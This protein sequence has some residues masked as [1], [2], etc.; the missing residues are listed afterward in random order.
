MAEAV[1]CISKDKDLQGTDGSGSLGGIDVRRR[2]PI[3]LISKQSNRNRVPSRT[4][5]NM[6][7]NSSKSLSTNEEGFDYNKEDIYDCK[8]GEVFGNQRRF[9]LQMFWDF[10]INLLGEKDDTPIH[11]C[12]KCGLPIKIYGRMIP[13]KHVFCFECASLHEKKGDKICPGCNDPVQRIEQ[14]L[15]GS[16]FMCSIVQGCKRTY[17]SQRDLQAHINHRHMRTGKPALR[18]QSEPLHPAMAPPG[19]IPERF[20]MPPDKHHISHIPPKQ[21]GL[22][23]PPPPLPHVSHEHYSQTHEDIRPPPAEM[24]LAPPPPRAVSQETFRISTVTTRKHSNLITVPIQDD[25]SSSG[26]R[27]PPVPAHHHPDYPSQPVVTHP[28]H[29]LPPQQHYAPPPPPPPPINHPL[30]HPSQAAGNPHMVYNPAPPPP[31]STAPPPITPPPGHILA[32]MPPYMN[33]PHGPPPPQHSGPPV[34]TPPPHHYS[35]T[36]M[37]QYTEDQGTL[38]P[39]FSQPGGHSPGI[40][41]WPAPRGPPPPPRMQVP[42]PQPQLP[43]PPHHPEQP[44]YRPYYQ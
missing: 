41:V 19:D 2:I 14:C 3:K 17:L 4:Q 10:K 35:A 1:F 25:S 38:S 26:N 39:P 12:D 43:G 28:H 7:R 16:L 6:N 44:R 40:G 21:H 27:E 24:S 9:T 32:Q 15:R 5:R 13:C 20:L 30:Q 18:P 42:P 8:S 34:N 33:H 11:F 31:M 36:S 29:M 37:P 23:M 22:M